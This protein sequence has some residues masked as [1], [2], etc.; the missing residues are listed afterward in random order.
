MTVLFFLH[1]GTT[2][3]RDDDFRSFLRS[4]PLSLRSPRRWSSLLSE[5]FSS[6]VVVLP[7]LPCKERASFDDWRLVFERY[8]SL[9]PSGEPIVLVGHSLG[10]LFLVRFLSEVVLPSDRR[11][12][13]S[14]L[15]AP[16]FEENGLSEELSGGFFVPDDLSLFGRQAGIL[17]FFFSRDDPVV[18]FAHQEKF[19][20]CLPSASFHT[21]SDAGHFLM[22]DFPLLFDLIRDLF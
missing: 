7:R 3:A 2:F 18:P 12:L 21:F 22:E 9:V 4:R 5:R 8:V 10:A 17:H 6:W 1:G 19:R 11:V 20:S 15:V 14:F 13:A 16:P